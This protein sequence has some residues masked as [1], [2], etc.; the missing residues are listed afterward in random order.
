MKKPALKKSPVEIKL[1][2]LSRENKRLKW[3]CSKLSSKLDDAFFTSSKLQHDCDAVFKANEHLQAGIDTKDKILNSKC[4]EL[5]TLAEEFKKLQAEVARVTADNAKYR[6]DSS[7]CRDAVTAMVT[8]FRAD[9]EATR[10]QNK[11][12]RDAV[13]VAL[14]A[15]T[16]EL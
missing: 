13:K 1:L 4:E 7:I 3:E 14:Q 16:P 15:L 9:C 10:A 2:S 6:E 5:E 11:K 12:L 8:D